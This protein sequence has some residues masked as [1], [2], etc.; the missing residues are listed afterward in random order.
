MITCERRGDV[1]VITID[2]PDQRNALDKAHCDELALTARGATA[3]G[4]RALVLTGSGSAFCAG[5]DFGEV[6]GL[7]FRR[8]LYAALGQ[9]RE[10]PVPVIAAV[11]GPAIGAGTQLAIAC[12]LRMVDATAVFGVPTAR[13]GLAVDPWTIRRIAALAGVA[14]A[15]SMVLGCETIDA[16]AAVLCGLA[17]RRGGLEAGVDWA[18]DIAAS[19]PL[20]LG[21]SKRVLQAIAGDATASS[22][23]LLD[24][25]FEKCW[26][27]EDLQEGRR[28]REE[29]RSAQFRGV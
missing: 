27:S 16:D 26:S 24:D 13:L 17:D 8:S 15:G 1:A 4:A 29:K 18:A 25:L 9:I 22:D 11:N 23:Q 14:S 6:Y 3:D 19:A 2:R 21:Y 10:L 12:D 28:A 7:A 5:A 20:T